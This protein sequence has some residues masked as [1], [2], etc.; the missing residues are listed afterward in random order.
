MFIITELNPNN[1]RSVILGPMKW[2]KRRFESVILDDTEVEVEL[3]QSNDP[4]TYIQ[5]SDTIEIWP[6]TG[7]Q[8]PIYNAK[9]Q[10]LHGPFYTYENGVAVSHNVAEDLPIDAVKSS[11]KNNVAANRY[12]YETS[13]CKVQIQGTEV[14]VDT[15]RDGRNIFIQKFMM[16]ND[17]DTVSWKFPEGF[18]TITKSELGEIVQAGAAHIQSKFEWEALK[19]AEIDATDTLVALDAVVLTSGENSGIPGMMQ[20]MPNGQYGN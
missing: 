10:R 15:S 13:G 19:D 2:L 12:K 5:V 17:S 16:M 8:D 11:L 3:P 20:G 4:E 9:I 18:F 14:S 7:S 6:V 1:T